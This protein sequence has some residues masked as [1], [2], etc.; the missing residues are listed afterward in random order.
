[1]GLI[2][3]YGARDALEAHHLRGILEDSGIRATVMGESLGSARGD[4]PVTVE[5]LPSVWVDKEDA[6]RAMEIVREFLRSDKAGQADSERAEAWTCPRCHERIEGQF[7]QC[8]NCGEARPT[9]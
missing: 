1:M 4:I 8:W 3:L 6:D 5:T 2:N 7:G 9:S